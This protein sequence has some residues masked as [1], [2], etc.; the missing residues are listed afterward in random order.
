[1][2]EKRP[3]GTPATAW[4]EAAAE[5]I[6]MSLILESLRKTPWE[7]IQE[8]GCALKLANSLRKAMLGFDGRTGTDSE[9]T[10]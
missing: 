4:E 2:N 10:D 3:S 8:H 6:D 1:M 7:R 5:G 9:S